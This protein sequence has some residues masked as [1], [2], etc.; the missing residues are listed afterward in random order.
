M[1]KITRRFLAQGNL[2]YN[3]ATSSLRM[4]VEAVTAV[5][6][7][8]LYCKILLFPWFTDSGTRVTL[9]KRLEPHKE[10]LSKTMVSTIASL[11]CGEGTIIVIFMK[12]TS[13][14]SFLARYIFMVN[15]ILSEELK[16]SV[17]KRFC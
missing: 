7:W 14:T 5:F 6:W 1:A 4:E 2:A 8:L 17:L 15:N 12:L 10:I 3:T 13:S 9:W 16:L 11:Q